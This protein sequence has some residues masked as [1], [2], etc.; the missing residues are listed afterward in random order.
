[1][2]QEPKCGFEEKKPCTRECIYFDTC[3]RSAK[4]GK[5][6]EK[7]SIM[8]YENI[9]RS[10]NMAINDFTKQV[11]VQ[12][13]R[14]ILGKDVTDYLIWCYGKSMAPG[15]RTGTPRTFFGLEVEVVYGKPGLIEVGYITT[16]QYNMRKG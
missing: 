7:P 16:A 4:K 12:P 9:V 8:N 2:E 14:L 5:A 3:T 15:K 10:V 11:G 1:M 13:N 6:K